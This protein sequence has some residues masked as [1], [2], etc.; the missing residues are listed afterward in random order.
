MF[1]ITMSL[2]GTTQAIL[3]ALEH[4]LLPD[5]RPVAQHLRTAGETAALETVVGIMGA[6]CLSYASATSAA[7]AASMQSAHS[8]HSTHTASLPVQPPVDELCQYEV[9]LSSLH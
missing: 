3:P 4:I 9:R 6:Y 1:G 7:A 8:M 5:V 2:D